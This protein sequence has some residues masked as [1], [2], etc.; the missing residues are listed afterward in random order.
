MLHSNNFLRGRFSIA[1]VEAMENLNLCVF[2]LVVL[3]ASTIKP[4]PD[5]GQ[6]RPYHIEVTSRTRIFELGTILIATL[7]SM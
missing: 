7:G 1:K 2:L 5:K 6:K 4:F 3:L